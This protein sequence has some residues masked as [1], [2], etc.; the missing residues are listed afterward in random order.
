MITFFSDGDFAVSSSGEVTTVNALNRESVASYSIVIEVIDSG[1]SP[2][3]TTTTLQVTVT[4]KHVQVCQHLFY[5][6]NYE[7][8]VLC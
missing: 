3:T 2:L 6:V 7:S 1:T 8:N 5:Y 4:G